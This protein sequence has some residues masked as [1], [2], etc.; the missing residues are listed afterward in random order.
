[1]D[2]KVTKMTWA[3]DAQALKEEAEWEITDTFSKF[4]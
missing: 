3:D 2:V 4:Q 1:M